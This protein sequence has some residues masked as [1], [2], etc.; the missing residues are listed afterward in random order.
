[1][2]KLIFAI[3]CVFSMAANAKNTT[4]PSIY[5]V[6]DLNDNKI[7]T[8]K[9]E[10][11]VH[12]MASLTKLM[13]A[14][15][16]LKYYPGNLKKCVSEVSNEDNDIIKN[17]H[18]RII[19]NKPISCENLLQLMLLV[20]DNYAASALAGSIPNKN[21]EDFFELMNKETKSIGMKNTFYKDSSGLSFENKTT[22]SDLLKLVK[23]L[24]KSEKLK[25]LASLYGLEL[26]TGEKNIIFKNSNKLIRENLFSADISK[27]GYISESGYNLVF[28][29]KAMCEKK[30]IVI[31]VMGAKNSQ[32]R[33]SFTKEMLEK[34][35]CQ[36]N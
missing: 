18:T 31:I 19:K 34:Y 3:I 5:E 14:H 11:Q 28:V 26:N 27:T 6:Y 25:E 36:K 2:K 21:R 4:T 29:N 16:F 30:K 23:I 13:T 32:Y 15:V 12:S 1:M 7:L 33:A 17:T 8:S 35:G 20:S 22:A 9:N 10:N 24:M